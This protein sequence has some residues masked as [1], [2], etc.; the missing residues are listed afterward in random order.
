MKAD[1]TTPMVTPVAKYKHPKT[2]NFLQWRY[3]KYSK[4]GTLCI[5]CVAPPSVNQVKLRVIIGLGYAKLFQNGIVEQYLSEW[6]QGKG[7]D[8]SVHITKTQRTSCH[9]KGTAQAPNEVRLCIQIH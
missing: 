7:G 8:I 2:T 9:T 5:D 1:W 6:R 3:D 4:A